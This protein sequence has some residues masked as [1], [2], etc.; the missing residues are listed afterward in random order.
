[1]TKLGY[2]LLFIS[3]AV[4]LLNAC[5]KQESSDTQPGKTDTVPVVKPPDV[6]PSAVYDLSQLSACNLFNSTP[7]VA[8]MARQDYNEL[9]GIAES[10]ATPGVL[11]VFEDGAKTSNIYLTNKLGADLGKVVLDGVSPRDWEDMVV[12]PGPDATKNYVY[13]ADIGDNN[14][15]YT[16]VSIYR[17]IEPNLS[18]AAA[19]S[20]IHVTAFDRIQISYSRGATNA[21]TL[22]I[23][24][25]TRDL[26]IA[27][28]ENSK[29]Y[30]YR[31]P[32]PQSTTTVAVIKPSA[33]LGFD[34]LT[35]GDISPDGKEVLLR[36]K[37]QIWYWKRNDGEDIVTTLLR[38]PQDAPYAA[39]E[40]QGE[41]ICFAADAGGYYTDTEIRDYPGAVSTISFYKRK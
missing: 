13:M 20:I 27:T 14:A 1:M 23:D 36:N 39:N 32:Y 16:S 8:N 29:S 37:S 9:S 22:M 4:V 28:K 11:Y 41:G 15:S 40:H 17:F 7:T 12:G 25:L 33:L 10:H 24:P 35:S 26:L 34:F 18:S 2:Q 19:G 3:A 5:S 31:I 30:I 21:E 38:K 6:I